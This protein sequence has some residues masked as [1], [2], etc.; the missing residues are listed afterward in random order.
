MARDTQVQPYLRADPIDSLVARYDNDQNP[1]PPHNFLD[2]MRFDEATLPPRDNLRKARRDQ[3]F[4]PLDRVKLEL[5]GKIGLEGFGG[6][7]ESAH[8]VIH[9]HDHLEFMESERDILIPSLESTT[10]KLSQ[11]ELERLEVE[12]FDLTKYNGYCEFLTAVTWSEDG[13]SGSVTLYKVNVGLRED[14]VGIRP[15]AA[16]QGVPKSILVSM[17]THEKIKRKAVFVPTDEDAQGF[18]WKANP[19]RGP[20]YVKVQDSVSAQPTVRMRSPSRERSSSHGYRGP[21]QVDAHGIKATIP[22]FVALMHSN[23]SILEQVQTTHIALLDTGDGGVMPAV[24]LVKAPRP[25]SHAGDG[26]HVAVLMP[27]EADWA[28]EHIYWIDEAGLTEF[29]RRK[30]WDLIERGRHGSRS[31]SRHSH[32]RHASPDD[33]HK[34]RSRSRHSGH[35]GSRSRSRHLSLN[36][37]F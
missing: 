14:A 31:R 28:D 32:S 26:V 18:K 21:S 7:I 4:A 9:S 24:A 37:I 29:R 13:E 16:M 23:R 15:V 30:Y 1:T 36:D 22:Q 25:N 3:I 20:T 17:R 19:S 10:E 12:L 35:G 27:N 8:S 5:P 6:I 11:R 33:R 2:W 34:S